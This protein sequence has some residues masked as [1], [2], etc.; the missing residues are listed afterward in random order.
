MQGE[1]A[2]RDRLSPRLQGL[3]TLVVAMALCGAAAAAPLHEKKLH[4]RRPPMQ[5]PAP[6]V[7]YIHCAME[8]GEGPCGIDPAMQRLRGEPPMRVP[9]ALPFDQPDFSPGR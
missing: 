8:L 3:A 6:P 2:M 4:V 1:L 9:R 7:R 5:K